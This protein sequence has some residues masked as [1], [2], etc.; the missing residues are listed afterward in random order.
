[1]IREAEMWILLHL[2]NCQH[3]GDPSAVVIIEDFY[4]AVDEGENSFYM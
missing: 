3:P 2:I 4:S 1:M